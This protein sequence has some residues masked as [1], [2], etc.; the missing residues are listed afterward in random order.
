[1]KKGNLSPSGPAVRLMQGWVDD[2]HVAYWSLAA[3][4]SGIHPSG[5]TH[6]KTLFAPVNLSL[7]HLTEHIKVKTI[8]F[9][10]S[11]QLIFIMT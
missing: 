7:Q 9:L 10:F 5:S 4:T 2:Y 6:Q 1:M 3:H 8:P 11:H